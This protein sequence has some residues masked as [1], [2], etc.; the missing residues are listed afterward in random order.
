MLLLSNGKSRVKVCELTGG[1]FFHW[2]NNRHALG[3]LQLEDCRAVWE[4]IQPRISFQKL[5]NCLSYYHGKTRGKISHFTVK[6]IQ[7]KEL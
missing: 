2:R 5:N 7:A 4:G 1:K 3:W 6:F